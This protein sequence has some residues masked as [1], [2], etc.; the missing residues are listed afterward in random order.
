MTEEYKKLSGSVE[1]TNLGEEAK[2]QIFT[3]QKEYFMYSLF[4]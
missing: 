2:G 4:L 3:V 1:P